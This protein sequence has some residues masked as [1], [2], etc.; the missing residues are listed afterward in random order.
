MMVDKL[1]HLHIT[2][3]NVEWYNCSGKF[4]TFFKCQICTYHTTQ[5]SHYCKF[6]PEGGKIDVHTKS[7]MLM[8]IAALFIMSNICTTPSFFKR[9]KR[10]KDYC[11]HLCLFCSLAYRIII[12]IFLN[13]IYM[14]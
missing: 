7:F 2:G 10:P 5:K 9:F 12:T 3:E 11:I 13:S 1:D 6:I 8:F 4:G 14:R